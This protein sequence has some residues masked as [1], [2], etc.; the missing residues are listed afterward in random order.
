LADRRYEPL[1][2]KTQRMRINGYGYRWL[3]LGGVY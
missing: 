1:N 3:R 2:P